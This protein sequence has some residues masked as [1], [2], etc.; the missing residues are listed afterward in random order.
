MNANGLEKKTRRYYT[1]GS[2]EI[3]VAKP[4]KV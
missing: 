1:T 3:L 2:F 4:M